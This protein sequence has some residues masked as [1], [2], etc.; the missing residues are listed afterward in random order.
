MFWRK[1][2]GKRSRGLTAVAGGKRRN[3]VRFR[4]PKAHRPPEGFFQTEWPD[5]RS[6]CVNRSIDHVQT[7]VSFLTFQSL[8]VFEC[9]WSALLCTATHSDALDTEAVSGPSLLNKSLSDTKFG[10]VQHSGHSV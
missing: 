7:T 1:M 9:L 8:P 4:V 10:S 3:D 5:K 2:D 6:L